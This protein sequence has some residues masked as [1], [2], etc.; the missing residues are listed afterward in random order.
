M[1]ES[2]LAADDAIR[3]QSVHSLAGA[4]IAFLLFACSLVAFVLA[5]SDVEVLRRT[6]WAPGIVGLLLAVVAC[7]HYGERGWRVRRDASA[8]GR[9]AAT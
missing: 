7:Q 2:V 8:P 6:M 4:G 3:A 1:S 9:A 5:S